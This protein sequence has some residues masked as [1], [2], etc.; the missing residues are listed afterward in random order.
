M[1]AFNVRRGGTRTRFWG[2]NGFS[3][4]KELKSWFSARR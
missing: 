1:Y 2:E 4:G 3:T